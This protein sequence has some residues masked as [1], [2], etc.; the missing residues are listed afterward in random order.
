[1]LGFEDDSVHRQWNLGRT[2]K[3]RKRMDIL[4]VGPQAPQVCYID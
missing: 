2:P 4:V 1:M 3:V